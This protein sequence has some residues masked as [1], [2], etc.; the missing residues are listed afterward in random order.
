MTWPLT[1]DCDLDLYCQNQCVV[2]GVS[3]HDALPFCEFELSL[4]LYFSE[5]LQRCIL[6]SDPRL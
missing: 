2:H 3:S 1:S 4:L 6:T 5:L